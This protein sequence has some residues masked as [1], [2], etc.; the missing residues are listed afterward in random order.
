M[1]VL[2]KVDDNHYRLDSPGPLSGTNSRFASNFFHVFSV[3]FVVNPDG[4]GT[5]TNLQAAIDELEVAQGG[6]IFLKGDITTTGITIPDNMQNLTIEGKNFPTITKSGSTPGAKGITIG[7]GCVNVILKN[8][9][10]KDFADAGDYALYAETTTPPDKIWI[11]KCL[12]TNYTN[13]HNFA[14]APVANYS[15]ATLID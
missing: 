12:L 9:V 13:N 2:I 15:T 5:H 10:I 6:T 3:E 1:G 4:T 14:A 7:D 8:L 11:D